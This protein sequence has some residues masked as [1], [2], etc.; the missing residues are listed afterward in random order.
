MIAVVP[1]D[2]RLLDP[3]ALGE[4][5]RRALP[6]YAVPAYLDVVTELPKTGTHRVIKADLK[7]RGVTSGTIRLDGP[8]ES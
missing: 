2:G 4:Y 8:M 7:Q 5:L 6:R 1:V 3:A